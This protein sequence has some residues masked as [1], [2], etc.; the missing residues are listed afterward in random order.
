MRIA[1]STALRGSILDMSR[2]QNL[3]FWVSQL[4]VVFS[5]IVG[6]YLASS[7]GL[8]SAVEFHYA[9]TTE[10][11]YYTLNALHAEVKNNND[12]ILEFGEKNLSKN[13][14]GEIHAHRSMRV[15][16]LNWFVWTTMTQSSDS[17]DLPVDI[18]RDVNI[19]YLSLLKTSGLYENSGGYDK[20]RHAKKINTLAEDTEAVL[21]ARITAQLEDYKDQMRDYKDLGQ[22]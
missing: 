21:L 1:I 12:L 3:I 22:Q 20:L 10:K 2:R 16:D 14:Q 18:L 13:E 19:Y 15:P 11:K 4:A 8:K 5:T 6:V 17:L 9:I 7:E